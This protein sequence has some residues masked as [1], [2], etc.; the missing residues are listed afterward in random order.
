MNPFLSEDYEEAAAAVAPGRPERPQPPLIAGEIVGHARQIRAPP[1]PPPPAKGG[2]GMSGEL[3]AGLSSSS[4][5]H[6]QKQQ[7]AP[8]NYDNLFASPKMEDGG[9]C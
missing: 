2:P 8:P 9:V 6:H 3:V 7:F 5:P 4:S 1:R